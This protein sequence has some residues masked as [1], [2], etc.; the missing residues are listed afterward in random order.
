M[1]DGV[2]S[3]A[4]RTETRRFM[5]WAGEAVTLQEVDRA[6]AYSYAAEHLPK[7]KT[8]RAP[9]G[10]SRATR[11]RA[12]SLLSGLWQWARKAGVISYEARTLGSTFRCRRRGRP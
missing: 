11:Q 1:P 6:M 9:N 3:R 7:V 10:L 8:P 5:E 12:I 2:S 4:L